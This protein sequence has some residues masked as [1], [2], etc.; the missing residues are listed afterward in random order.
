M[1]P[2]AKIQ[3]P[4][5]VILRQRPAEMPRRL[6]IR[7]VPR[8]IEHVER[9]RREQFP[10]P[11][12]LHDVPRGADI[13]GDNRR[14]RLKDRIG[15]VAMMIDG[16]GDH[17]FFQNLVGEDSAKRKCFVRSVLPLHH[18]DQSI[19]LE[20]K[21]AVHGQELLAKDP[22]LEQGSQLGSRVG[23]GVG[24]HRCDGFSIDGVLDRL[25][26]LLLDIQ[27]LGRDLPDDVGPPKIIIV[28]RILRT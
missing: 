23:R 28:L 21:I 15:D 2:V 13:P 14:H 20:R 11:T 22:G 27:P 8:A 26:N 5:S 18:I 4:Q 24:E 19:G 12:P 17:G 9:I 7:H 16:Q 3:S 1:L 10:Q 6:D 25:K